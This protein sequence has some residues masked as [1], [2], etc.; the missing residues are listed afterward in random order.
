M[1]LEDRINAF[2]KIGEVFFTFQTSRIFKESIEKAQREN[3]WF[4]KSNIEYA[5][6]SLAKMLNKEQLREWSSRYNMSLNPKT[7]GVIIPANIPL[8]GFYDFLCVLLSGN[9]F[10]GKLS[11]SNTVLLPFVAKIL[12]DI[13]PKFK[14]YIFFQNNLDDVDLLIATGNDN[15]ADYFNFLFKNK[16][17]IIRK[18]RNSIAI[19]D[20]RETDDEY[21]KLSYDIFMYFGLGCRNVSKLFVPRSFDFNH[22][23]AIFQDA[24]NITCQAYLDNYNY[25]KSILNMHAIDFLDFNNLLVV[26][27][28]YV[29][30]PIAV[31][32]YQ[33]YDSSSVIDEFLNFHRD[34]IQCIV[35]RN[36]LI[37]F[38]KTQAPLVFNPPDNIDVMRFLSSD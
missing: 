1:V 19:L 35:G 24:F 30:S 3:P 20:G 14:N 27:S 31:L 33:Y 23:K 29:N 10:I 34:S 9:I 37:D 11:S 16:R 36:S 28:E 21:K 26:E 25:Q 17:K 6:L 22:L 8:V 38:G 5:V 12:C 4:L 2:E 32:Y 7:V 13:N 15:S 18:N